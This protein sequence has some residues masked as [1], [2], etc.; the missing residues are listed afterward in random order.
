MCQKGVYAKCESVRW[1]MKLWRQERSVSS[2]CA[3]K[4]LYGAERMKCSFPSS[5]PVQNNFPPGQRV[6]TLVPMFHVMM[7]SCRTTIKEIKVPKPAMMHEGGQ[8]PALISYVCIMIQHRR[9]DRGSISRKRPRNRRL[10]RRKAMRSED[11]Q[12]V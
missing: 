11:S 7:T 3:S 8:G 5:G 10:T 6:K 4:L 1:I 2:N 12:G 9:R